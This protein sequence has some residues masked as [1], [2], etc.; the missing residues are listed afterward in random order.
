MARRFQLLPSKLRDPYY[1][2]VS[3]L[4]QETSRSYG[5]PGKAPLN[6]TSTV[7]G[8][9]ARRRLVTW[10]HSQMRWHSEGRDVGI[11]YIYPVPSRLCEDAENNPAVDP[12]A[13]SCHRGRARTTSHYCI[14]ISCSFL[15]LVRSRSDLSHASGLFYFIANV[16]LCDFAWFLYPYGTRLRLQYTA[17]QS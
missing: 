1:S 8:P 12:M 13:T 6:Y 5:C 7:I 10:R 15:Y 9:H 11:M 14:L 2:S 17:R 4:R 3:R 16:T